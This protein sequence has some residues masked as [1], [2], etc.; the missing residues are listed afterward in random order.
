[1]FENDQR[2]LMKKV[3][4]IVRHNKETFLTS[5]EETKPSLNLVLCGRRGA[6][7]TS[8][9]KAILGQTELHLVSPTS[10]EVLNQ[11][12]GRWVSGDGLP[13]MENSETVMEEHLVFSVILR[14]DPCFISVLPVGPLN[15]G[16]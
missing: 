4:N 10:S 14:G 12:E 2:L 1:M 8:A 11:G 9:A 3:G 7:K 15:D 13:C 5:T 6:G 16:T